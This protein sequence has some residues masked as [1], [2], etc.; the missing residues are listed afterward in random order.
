M[1]NKKLIL[2]IAAGV[3]ALAVAGVICK[4]KGLID[5]DSICDKAGDLASNV[6]DKFNNLKD[7]AGKELD[8]AIDTG[9]K[10]AEKAVSSANDAA[11]TAK[12]ATT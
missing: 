10:Y 9:K 4:K 5:F 1:S 12:N 7:S 8:A 6:K 3:A 2:G 11:D